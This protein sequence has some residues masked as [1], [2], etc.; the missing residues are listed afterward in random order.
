MA[1]KEVQLKIRTAAEYDVLYPKTTISAV[2][3]LSSALASLTAHRHAD[4]LNN[5]SITSTPVTPTTSD[6]IVMTDASATPAHALKRGPVFNETHNDSFLRKDGS[7]QPVPTTTH[8]HAYLADT[9]PAKDVTAGLITNWT[10]AY[11]DTSEATNLNT[12]SKIVKRDGSRN[13]SANT[14]TTNSVKIGNGEV[15]MVYD[16]VNDEVKFIWS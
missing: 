6:A 11:T 14:I 3:G 15:E 4:L 5:G 10:S 1:N 9:H 16:S 12:A 13:F 2:Q 8:T 7:W